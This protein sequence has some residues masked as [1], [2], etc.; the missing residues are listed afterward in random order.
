MDAR[1]APYP[2]YHNEPS[3]VAAAFRVALWEQPE[4][5]DI[6]PEHLAWHEMTFDLVGI[7]D[8]REAIAWAEGR[9]AAGKGPLSEDGVSVQDREYVIYAKSPTTSRWLHVAGW[10]P[11]RPPEAPHNLGRLRVIPEHWPR[12]GSPRATLLPYSSVPNFSR[13]RS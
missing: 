3:E 1:P 13:S 7:E 2:D 6:D 8:V 9:L 12:R 10:L 4:N 11:T 5:S